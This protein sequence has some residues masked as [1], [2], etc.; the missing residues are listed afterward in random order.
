MIF[1]QRF[2]YN[3]DMLLDWHSSKY[4]I[5]LFLQSQI[6]QAHIRRNLIAISWNGLSCIW[7]QPIFAIDAIDSMVLNPLH[8]LFGQTFLVTFCTRRKV[9]LYCLPSISQNLSKINQFI[10]CN[11]KQRY[12]NSK[13]SRLYRAKQTWIESTYSHL[14][15]DNWKSVLSSPGNCDGQLIWGTMILNLD[16][17][18][19]PWTLT[20]N[21]RIQKP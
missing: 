10:K 4:P 14:S 8:R 3:W 11:Q 19:Q 1:L 17:S 2:V 20:I 6:Y 13:K 15:S 12:C 21:S 7:M 5:P 16:L 9:S 18:R